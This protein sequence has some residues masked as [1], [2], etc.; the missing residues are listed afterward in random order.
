MGRKHSKIIGHHLIAMNNNNELEGRDLMIMKHSQDLFNI[1]K[2]MKDL[3]RQNLASI[4]LALFASKPS[5]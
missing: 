3:L 1:L 5:K 4:E 2:V